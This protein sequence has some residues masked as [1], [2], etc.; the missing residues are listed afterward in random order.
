MSKRSCTFLCSKAQNE[1]GQDSLDIQ[2]HKYTPSDLIIYRKGAKNVEIVKNI[3]Y[4][5]IEESKM[6]ASI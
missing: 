4:F 2:C 1:N 3:E 5:Y 6:Y